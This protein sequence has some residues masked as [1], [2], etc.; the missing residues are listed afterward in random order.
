[1]SELPVF[2]QVLLSIVAFLAGFVYGVWL[3][4]RRIHLEGRY[5]EEQ[6]KIEYHRLDQ[7]MRAGLFGAWRE[8]D[9][10]EAYIKK[11][12]AYDKMD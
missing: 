5:R 3:K 4:I 11:R 12:V 10:R 1:M 6:R 9:N 7:V 2:V 8:V